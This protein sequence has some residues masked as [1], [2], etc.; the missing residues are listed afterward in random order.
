MHP[1]VVSLHAAGLPDG[2]EEGTQASPVWLR[3]KYLRH[4]V[5]AVRCLRYIFPAVLQELLLFL[6]SMVHHHLCAFVSLF[7]QGDGIAKYLLRDNSVVL[8]ITLVLRALV[9]VMEYL[10]TPCELCTEIRCRLP[11][12]YAWRQPG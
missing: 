11:S 5:D 4:A 6:R 7:T 12:L 10:A 9:V 2:V 3:L 8:L 1:A